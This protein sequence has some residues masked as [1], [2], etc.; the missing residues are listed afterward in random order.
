MHNTGYPSL[1]LN[2]LAASVPLVLISGRASSPFILCNGSALTF[3]ITRPF[4]DY[5][6][7]CLTHAGIMTDRSVMKRP[8]VLT[9]G[10]LERYPTLNDRYATTL[11]FNDSAAP[12]E[13]NYLSM[14]WFPVCQKCKPSVPFFRNK[15]MCIKRTEERWEVS[16]PFRATTLDPLSLDFCHTTIVCTPNKASLTEIYDI[17]VLTSP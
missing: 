8:V 15:A 14:K 6:P 2:Q 17:V 3:T 11:P 1:T 16:S 7:I 5:K 9:L 10:D 4:L 12:C 13:C